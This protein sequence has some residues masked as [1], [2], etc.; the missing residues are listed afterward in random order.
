MTA[1][2][3][4]VVR[5]PSVGEGGSRWFLHNL[6]TILVSGR[7]TEGRLGVVEMVGA[8]GDMPPL[9]V[10][11][12]EDEVFFVLD[13]RL[14]IHLPGETATIEAGQTAFARRGSPHV[15]RVESDTARWLVMVSPSRFDRFL[16]ET[17][18]PA[19]E[20]TLPPDRV[21]LPDPAWLTERAAAYEI[22]ILGPPG[23]LPPITGEDSSA[24][25]T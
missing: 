4:R 3:H 21:P 17:S 8:A 2:M 11:S 22:E 5:A 18:V 25:S 7:E 1:T 10:H 23:T 15:Y 16:E 6:S 9:H 19:D 20:L 24:S 13:G 14:S 12:G